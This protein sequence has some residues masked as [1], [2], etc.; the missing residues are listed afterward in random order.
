MPTHMLTNTLHTYRMNLCVCTG[1]RSVD[2][3]LNSTQALLQ[4][5]EE[6]VRRGEREK[7]TLVEQVKEFERTL[8]NAEM[9]RRHLQVHRN[10][11]VHIYMHTQKH[12]HTQSLEIVL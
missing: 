12:K 5:Q 10:T 4:Q 9:E 8:Q 1:K 11:H 2:G 3:R 7:R 6:A